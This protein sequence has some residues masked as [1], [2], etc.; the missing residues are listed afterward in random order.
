MVRVTHIPGGQVPVFAGND[1]MELF[2]GEQP[3]LL[4]VVT[5][6]V[7]DDIVTG[8]DIFKIEVQVGIDAHCMI[9]NPANEIIFG[10]GGGTPVRKNHKRLSAFL[11][12][13]GMGWNYI[14]VK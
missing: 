12:F 10:D 6:K 1:G 13:S 4:K 8:P 14:P 2:P 7:C 3:A 5:V 9:W 11:I